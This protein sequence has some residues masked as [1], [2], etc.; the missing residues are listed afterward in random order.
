M[1]LLPSAN[2]HSPGAFTTNIKHLNVEPNN[3]DIVVGD[4]VYWRNLDN[5]ENITHRIVYDE[6]G[7][8]LYN[9][10]NEWDSTKHM[11]GSNTGHED[12]LL[13]Y[14]GK[15]YSP[16]Q[17][18][19]SGDFRYAN[20]PSPSNP[21]Y[22]SVSGLRTF[23]RKFKNT[24]GR[25]VDNISWVTV[26]SGVTL[27]GEGDAVGSNGNAR[28]FFKHPGH[29]EWLDAKTA[30]AYHTITDRAGGAAPSGGAGDTSLASATNYVTF[31]SGSIPNNQQIVMKVEADAGW[32][33]NLDSV[34]VNFG[35]EGAR[36]V[37]P[38][39]VSGRVVKTLITS[40]FFEEEILKF[41]SQP[42][43]LP[44]QFFCINFTLFGQVFSLSKSF[45]SSSEYLDILKNH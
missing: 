34:T 39:M 44:I 42:T 40:F 22:S 33:G 12:G 11:S 29:T 27:V 23:Y 43:D 25:S 21:D 36:N 26:G 9:G 18:G 4:S 35:A 30:F 2:S 10:S 31:G 14:I 37:A 8:G 28:V 16:K 6:N 5:R 32:T 45:N 38:K 13:F 15:L 19:D 41:N 17:G 20:G 7:D 3:V 24:S 1:V